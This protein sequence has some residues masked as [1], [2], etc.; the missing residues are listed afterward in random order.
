MLWFE[1]ACQV[2]NQQ[3]A[4]QAIIEAHLS[5]VPCALLLM[6]AGLRDVLFA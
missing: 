6:A 1:K 3:L 2:P 5:S 4:K